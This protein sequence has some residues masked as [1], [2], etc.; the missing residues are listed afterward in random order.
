MLTLS[1]MVPRHLRPRYGCVHAACYTQRG[2]EKFTV[3]KFIR[4]LIQLR[5]KNHHLRQ[6][7]NN[8]DTI[9]SNHTFQAGNTLTKREKQSSNSFTSTELTLYWP[10]TLHT[11][12]SS[13]SLIF[14]RL[15]PY[16][17]RSRRPW[18]LRGRQRRKFLGPGRSR[19][20]ILRG[21][22]TGSRLTS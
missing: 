19:V 12:S 1:L 7:N 20:L 2:D 15:S 14:R 9:H 21:N 16:W 4:F 18:D 6:L 17:I 11:A 22:I 5:Y 3:T 13:S 10:N 8:H